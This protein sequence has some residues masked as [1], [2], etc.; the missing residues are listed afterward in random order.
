MKTKLFILG[1][2]LIAA[3]A[4]A[5]AQTTP[6][7]KKTPSTAKCSGKCKCGRFVDDNNDKTCDKLATRNVPF[8]SDK[9]KEQAKA[10]ETKK[11]PKTKKQ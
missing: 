4:F 1:M 9:K 2:A 3:T 6:G 8:S 10:V 7:E 11:A 5:S